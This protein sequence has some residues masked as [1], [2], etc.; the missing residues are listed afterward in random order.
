[1]I[2]KDS[3][4]LL[5]VDDHPVVRDGL[6]AILSIQPDFQVIGEATSGE[7]ALAFVRQHQPDVILMDLEMPGMDGVE[8]IRLLREDQPDVRV[9][10]FTAFDTD[11]RILNAVQAG[12]KGY[13]LK[14]APRDE[15]FNAVRVVHQGGSLLQPVVASRLLDRLAADESSAGQFEEL[16]PRE[17]EVLTLLAQGMQNKE[18]AAELLIAERTVKF[19]ITSI[20]AKLGAGN[21]T[22]AVTVALQLGLVEL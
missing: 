2:M 7:D 21:R 17:Q 11:E 1:M 15:L 10:V 6:V 12:A 18:I 19:H 16:T 4:K 5:I 14:G 9:V 20:L 13:L 3:I 22:E 8:T